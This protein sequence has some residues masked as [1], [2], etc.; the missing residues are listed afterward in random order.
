ML[1]ILSGRRNKFYAS[2]ALVRYLS[3]TSTSLVKL[4]PKDSLIP[5]FKFPKHT[6]TVQQISQ[7]IDSYWGKKVQISGWI[8]KK[9]KKISKNIA[10]ASIR[11]F[12]GNIT[13]IVTTDPELATVLKNSQIEDCISVNGIIEKRHARNDRDTD[14]R[15][16]LRIMEYNTLNNS[17]VL[18]AQ[19]ES[20]KSTPDAFPPQYRYLQL[21]LPSFQQA[22]KK[23]A[24]AASIIREQLN[25]LSFTEVETPLLFKSTPEGA[26]EFL[27]PTRKES[28]FYALPQSPQQY[29][30]LLMASGIKNYFQIA[31]CFRDEDLRADR[32][33]EFT[34]V[35]LEMSFADAQDVQNVIESTVKRVWEEVAKDEIMT[36]NDVGDVQKGAF[37][38]LSYDEVLSKYGIDKPD[39]RSTI[40][41]QDLTGFA[42]SK[43]DSSFPI[44]EVCI[45][46]NAFEVGKSSKLPKKLFDD[47]EYKTRKPIIFPI[48]TEKDLKEWQ[49]RFQEIA[50]I[51]DSKGLNEKINLKIGDII[52]GSTRAKLSYENP[53]P[54]G[55]FRQLSIQEFPNKW[56]RNAKFIGA[57]IEEFP[58]FTPFE[59]ST[60]IIK[61][62]YPIYNFNK[63]ESTH[64]PFTMVNPRDYLLLETSPLKA[65]GEHYDLVINGVELGGGSRRIH[66]SQLQRF[67]FTKILKIEN[68]DKLFGHL[69]KALSLGCPPHAGFAIGF[70]RMCAMLIG[71]NSIRDVVA[72]PKTQNGADLVV[73][74][75]SN[76][77][78]EILKEYYVKKLRNY[79]IF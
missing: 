36:I 42:K 45:L 74:S 16:D 54:L 68:P 49:T 33:P 70:D 28:S 59:E 24:Q 52:A 43:E 3:S 46:K 71:S 10:F 18:T 67:I 78:D 37:V 8:D 44:F 77:S 17:D 47:G 15:W 6:H 40:E 9:P 7:D 21:R 63:L 57:W 55:R 32:Q 50:D 69:L 61:G 19:L 39:L 79:E 48:K 51:Q 38:H 14:V 73:E 60:T 13:Q 34:Q 76:V 12:E 23:R 11:D 5:K 56:K 30:Q 66:D 27:V 65:K 26:R 58:L 25:K 72:F 31:K 29:K 2:T 22:L 64:H 20:L 41:I 1:R 53:T 62:K 35:D 4:P 75:P